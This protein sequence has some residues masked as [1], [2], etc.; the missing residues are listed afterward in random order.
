MIYQKDPKKQQRV[1]SV[2]KGV[3]TLNNSKALG[4]QGS[5]WHN[6]KKNQGVK[7]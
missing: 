1:L 4:G 2:N 3:K 7:C 6:L 5:R